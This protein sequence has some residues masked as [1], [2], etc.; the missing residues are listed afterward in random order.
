MNYIDI[1]LLHSR[2]TYLHDSSDNIL[3]PGSADI[4]STTSKPNSDVNRI[5]KVLWSPH[6]FHRLI[7]LI[8]NAT[9]K[10]R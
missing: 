2:A 8:T 4:W 6:Q 9:I 7:I 3:F 10:G 5:W 1:D